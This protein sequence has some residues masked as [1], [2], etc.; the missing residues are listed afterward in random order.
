[1]VVDVIGVIVPIH[2]ISSMSTGN[3]KV[4][5][6]ESFEFFQNTGMVQHE[7]QTREWAP[8]SK[9]CWPVPLRMPPPRRPRV[10]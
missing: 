1:M 4:A 2:I 6:D 5:F 8:P 7:T 9:D 10:R 3:E